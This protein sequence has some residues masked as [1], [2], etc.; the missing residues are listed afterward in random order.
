MQRKLFTILFAAFV[1]LSA[2]K[3]FAT[4]SDD[5]DNVVTPPSRVPDASSTAML[6]GCAATGLAG[7]RFYFRKKH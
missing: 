6:V 2:N 7:L 1:L 4:L 5:D 3:A